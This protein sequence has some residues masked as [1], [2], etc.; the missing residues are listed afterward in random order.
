MRA[1][2]T[3]SGQAGF[4]LIEAMVAILV[5]V[6]GLMAIASLF[7]MAG[8]SNSVANQG[9]AAAT[10]ASETM[11]RLRALPWDSL[12]AGGGLAAVSCSSPGNYGRCDDIAGVGRINTR[13][14]IETVASNLYFITVR[15]E[16]MGAV[17]RERSRAE[18]TMFRSC[19]NAAAGCP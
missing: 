3:N 9:T 4:T 11:E 13:W 2:R 14:Q 18:F 19:T 17:A 7:A 5:L 16:G 10:A 1:E 12:S 15:S 8:T 6:F